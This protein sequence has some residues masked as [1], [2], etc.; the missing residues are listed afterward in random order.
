MV[1]RDQLGN[2][3]ALVQGLEPEALALG[4]LAKPFPVA[5]YRRGGEAENLGLGIPVYDRLPCLRPRMVRLVDHNHV[6]REFRLAPRPGEHHPDLNGRPRCRHPPR[7][8]DA[9]IGIEAA[10]LQGL[11]E[12]PRQLPAVDEDEG[13]E[14]VLAQPLDDKARDHAFPAARWKLIKD[15]LP[16]PH[17]LPQGGNVRGLKRPEVEYGH[18]SGGGQPPHDAILDQI[19]KSILIQGRNIEVG[20]THKECGR[21]GPALERRH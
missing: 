4:V 5:P 20:T 21:A 8:D 16:V 7:A 15:R 14:S 1:R 19:V 3:G 10:R 12:L 2:A 17:Q 9:D 11:H 18:L 13:L 6:W